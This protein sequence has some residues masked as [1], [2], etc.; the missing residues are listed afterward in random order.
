MLRVTDFVPKG[1]ISGVRVH[2][3]LHLDM[4]RVPHIMPALISAL[5]APFEKKHKKSINE[6]FSSVFEHYL[7]FLNRKGCKTPENLKRLLPAVK[8]CHL[9][10]LFISIKFLVTFFFSSRKFITVNDEK[11]KNVG[12]CCN[13]ASALQYLLQHLQVAIGKHHSEI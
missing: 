3:G 7:P 8:F 13:A 10:F 5:N 2:A 4:L 1:I 9:S 12:Q 6:H 11:K